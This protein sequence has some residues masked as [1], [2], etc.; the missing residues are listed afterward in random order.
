MVAALFVAPLAPIVAG[1]A[2]VVGDRSIRPVSR[3]TAYLVSLLVTVVSLLACALIAK[4]RPV[5]DRQWVP[6]IGMRL[7]LAVDGISVPLLLMTAAI[8]VLVV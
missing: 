5:L 3:H 8:G 6:E 1:L 4:D 2:L 7:H